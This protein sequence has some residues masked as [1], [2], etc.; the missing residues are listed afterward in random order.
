MKARRGGSVI[1][2]PESWQ[3]GN[4]P[5]RDPLRDPAA[6]LTQE[7]NS[8]PLKFMLRIK[9]I[10]APSARQCTPAS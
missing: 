5:P 10:I 7:G 8:L 6:L 1:R 4:H 3:L 2:N 9:L